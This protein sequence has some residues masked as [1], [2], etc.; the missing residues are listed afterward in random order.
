MTD[1]YETDAFSMRIFRLLYLWADEGNRT[2]AFGRASHS[3]L[4][5]LDAAFDADDSVHAIA[6]QP[7]KN[8]SVRIF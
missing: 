1:C 6:M 3:R 2:A 4:E 8:C 5:A 7:K